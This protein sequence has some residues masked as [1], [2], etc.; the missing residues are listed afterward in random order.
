MLARDLCF[1]FGAGVN[2]ALPGRGCFEGEKG[3]AVAAPA[4]AQY[5]SRRQQFLVGRVK[6]GV[7]HCQARWRTKG[8]V[9]DMIQR[10]QPAR[11]DLAGYNE[12]G[13]DFHLGGNRNKSPFRKGRTLSVLTFSLFQLPEAVK[14]TETM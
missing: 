8:K 10:A 2:C 7:A 6:K 4:N 9:G 13:F 3:L 12:L 14:G 1:D 11:E 5:N